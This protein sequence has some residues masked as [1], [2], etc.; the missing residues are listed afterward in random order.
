MKVDA[1]QRRAF[2]GSGGGT[3]GLLAMG[4]GTAILSAAE[5]TKGKKVPA[6]LQAAR[7]KLLA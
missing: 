3:L 4:G 6:D 7:D 5:A 2:L 1:M